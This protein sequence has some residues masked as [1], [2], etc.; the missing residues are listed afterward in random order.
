LIPA[1][2]VRRYADALFRSAQKAGLIDAVESDLG[3]VSYVF[4]SSADLWEAIKSP[5]V[6]SEKKH[7]IL[8]DVLAG[9]VQQVTLD[10]L[11]LL[12]DKRREGVIPQTEG[13]YVALANEARGLIVADVTTAVDLDSETENRLKLKLG[14]VTGKQVR[15]NRTVDPDIKGGMIVKIGDRVIDGSIRGRLEELR[16][17]LSE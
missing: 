4:E 14:Q 9:K 13:E 12:V 1:R 11:D 16:E 15:L 2:I 8:R 6:S 7:E 17:K 10:Y 5:V 3:L